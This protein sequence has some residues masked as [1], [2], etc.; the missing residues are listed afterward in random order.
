[1]PEFS[2]AM[3]KTT[4]TLLGE[5]V[6][7]PRYEPRPP[8]YDTRVLH[9][10]PQC[11]GHC[12]FIVVMNKKCCEPVHYVTSGLGIFMTSSW[13]YLS[14][15]NFYWA[16]NA[17]SPLLYCNKSTRNSPISETR[18]SVLQVMHYLH[19]EELLNSLTLIIKRVCSRVTSRWS[20]ICLGGRRK[21][22]YIPISLRAIRA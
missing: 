20:R 10:R 15:F 19:P 13:S 8:E 1:M 2:W 4:N 5:P 3:R 22:R 21:E 14:Q 6:F 16:V 12:C 9:T 18:Q 17:G 7:E 11:S